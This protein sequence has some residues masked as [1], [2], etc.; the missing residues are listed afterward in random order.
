[1]SFEVWHEANKILVIHLF[2][3]R[4]KD[5]ILC[6]LSQ[7]KRG[8]GGPGLLG[9]KSPLVRKFGS[10]FGLCFLYRLKWT[11]W[12]VLSCDTSHCFQA[13]EFPLF[14]MLSIQHDQHVI[15]GLLQLRCEKGCSA[16]LN[17][18]DLLDVRLSTKFVLN[19][20]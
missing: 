10:F 12:I 20:F 17:C 4:L 9:D 11:V 8:G 7:E 6:V 1:M 2:V 19:F 15:S 18:N 5:C 3:K 16:K 14:S 13:T